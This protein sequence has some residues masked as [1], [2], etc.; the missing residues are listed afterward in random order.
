[1]LQREIL[2]LRELREQLLEEVKL[3]PMPLSQ[4]IEDMVK[5]VQEN[6]T[7]DKLVTG[8]SSQKDIWAASAKGDGCIVLWCWVL[9]SYIISV[10]WTVWTRLNP[11]YGPYIAE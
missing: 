10:M 7:D 3:Q 1:M 9:Q 5:F 6:E 2:A 4:A 11:A 8:V